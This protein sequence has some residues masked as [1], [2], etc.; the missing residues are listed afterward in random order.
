MN[1]FRGRCVISGSIKTTCVVSRRNVNL[2]ASFKASVLAGKRRVYCADQDNPDLFGRRLDGRILCLP[3][4]V[5][6]TT[7]GLVLHSLCKTP[8]AP[9][10]LLFAGPIDPVTAAGVI[11]AEEWMGKSIPTIDRLGEEFL[12]AV[13]HGM[14][15]EVTPE[16]TIMCFD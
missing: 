3:A 2:T 7:A 12:D 16:G 6:A 5:G 13:E 11:L 10:A 4:I 8:M 15:I 1:S 9:A 14:V